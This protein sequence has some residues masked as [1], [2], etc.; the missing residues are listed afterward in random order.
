MVAKLVGPNSA[1]FT[2]WM[3]GDAE[4]E[5]IDWFDNTASYDSS[6]GMDV[7]VLKADHHGSCNG[8]TSRLLDLVTPAYVTM[9]VG[10]SNG[11]GHVHT[12]TKTLLSGR[13]VPWYRTDTNGRITIT[14]PGTVG[15]GYTVS[16]A[17]GTA[18]MDGASDATSA[19]TDCNSL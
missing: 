16:V 10:S 17:S 14:T 19:D 9:G 1:S 15:G 6:P 8:I 13:A 18:S 11:Y 12:Q 5:A 3:A 4:H 2:M 7:D